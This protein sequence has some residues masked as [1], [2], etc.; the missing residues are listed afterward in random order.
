LR[1]AFEPEVAGR[2]RFAKQEAGDC[3]AEDRERDDRDDADHGGAVSL[4]SGA[5]CH[6]YLLSASCS[7]E[8]L[9]PFG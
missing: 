6:A 3:E 8:R 5:W 7:F 2:L 9:F 4:E 1:E